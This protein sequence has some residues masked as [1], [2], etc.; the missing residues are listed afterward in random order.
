[1]A[2]NIT[3]SIATCNAYALIVDVDADGNVTAT[4]SE[5]VPFVSTNPSDADAARALRNAGIKADKKFIRF[6]IVA[7]N[8]YAMTMDDF[9]AHATI[10][11]RG[12][13]GYVRKSDL[14][15]TED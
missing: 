9:I 11:E 8:V 2:A 12:K 6:E 4:P 10:V 14:A 3:R 1:M 13:G 7:E 15:K 5:K